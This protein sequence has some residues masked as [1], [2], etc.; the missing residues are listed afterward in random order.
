MNLWQKET[1]CPLC[2]YGCG[3]GIEMRRGFFPKI[4]YT[5]PLC[6]RGNAIPHILF[7]PQRLYSPRWQG[8][9]I[10]WEN[11]LFE[12]KKLIRGFPSERVAIGFDGSLTRE[13]RLAV[14]NLGKALGIKY[15]AQFELEN[16]TSYLVEGIKIATKKDLAESE[17]ILVIGDLFS[18]FPLFAHLLLDA[19]YNKKAKI[20]G[21]D[22][23]PNRLSWFA[24][25]FF[26]CSPGKEVDLV[27]KGEEKVFSLFTQ[28]KRGL[29]ILDAPPGKF[30][31]PFGLHLACQIFLSRIQG[32]RYYL[33][34]SQRVGDKGTTASGEVW[35]RLKGGEVSLFLFFGEHLPVGFPFPEYS[36]LFIP[37]RINFGKEK[38]LLL[39]IPHQVEREGKIL[40]FWGETFKN[41]LLPYSGT[42]DLREIIGEVAKDLGDQPPAEMRGDFPRMTKKEAE[43]LLT[44]GEEMEPNGEGFYIFND[45]KAIEFGG[46]FAS[47]DYLKISPE[48]ARSL[49]VKEGEWLSLDSEKGANPIR[50]RVK[51]KEGLSSGWALVSLSHPEVRKLFPVSIDSRIKEIILKPIRVRIW[52]EE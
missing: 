12:A 7:S 5:G 10:S 4:N 25:E 1:I 33:P 19:K 23:F 41:G 49:G 52:K 45:E 46:F 34:V 17:V 44:M 9:E 50:L 35:E 51:I 37:W 22:Y 39:P 27:K 11:G 18:R 29:L 20:F 38:F 3:L 47:G 24:D 26:I 15:I 13:E 43:R 32:E 14:K 16:F 30:F 42:K 2:P 6:A 48:D 8:K 21:F 36:I 28:A 31:D 40:T